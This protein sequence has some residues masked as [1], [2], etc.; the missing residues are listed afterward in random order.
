MI[1]LIL[2]MVDAEGMTGFKVFGLI[3]CLIFLVIAGIK[4]YKE[5]K[6]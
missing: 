1:R 5:L 2:S 6:K 3:L 4:L